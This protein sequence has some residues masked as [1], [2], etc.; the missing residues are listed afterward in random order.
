MLH[1]LPYNTSGSKTLR[2]AE[3]CIAILCS[4]IAGVSGVAMGL[5]AV[6]VNSEGHRT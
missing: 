4:S 3:E 6:L 1:L 5:F 2:K